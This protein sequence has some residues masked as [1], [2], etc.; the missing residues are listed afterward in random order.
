MEYASYLAGEKWSD[1]PKCTHPLLA[2]V[3]RVVNDQISD[4]GRSRLVPWIPS[5]IGLTGDDPAVDVGIAMR[6]AA[7]ALPIVAEYRQR[8]L[9]VG[10]LTARQVLTDLTEEGLTDIDVSDLNH[11]AERSL[12]MSAHVDRWAEDFI[13]GRR[14]TPK[15][16]RRRS[17]PAIVRVAVVGISEAC[18]PDSDS[19][20]SELLTTVIR[21]CNG[22]L[23]S[24]SKSDSVD[25]GAVADLRRPSQLIL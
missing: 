23:G 3:A 11:H 19:R 12:A 24:T 6:C 9:A 5:V 16:F 15:A 13:T 8:A 18:I 10:L 7:L 14:I 25:R 22:W 20:L 4:E 1:H 2:G 21:D 17:A